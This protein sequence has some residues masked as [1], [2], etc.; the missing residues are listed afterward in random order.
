[1]TQRI[2]KI[3]PTRAQIWLADLEPS[4]GDEVRKARPVLIIGRNGLCPLR[5]AIICPIRARN[6]KHDRYDWLIKVTPDASNGLDK[7]SSIDAFQVRCVSFKRMIRLIGRL[8]EETVVTVAKA[9]A[10]CVGFQIQDG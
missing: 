2:S 6:R 7:V 5:L 9:V 8:D 3:T 10:V 1:M 4:V